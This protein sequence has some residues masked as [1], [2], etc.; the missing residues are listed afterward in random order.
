VEQFP[1]E[2]V[3]LLDEFRAYEVRRDDLMKLMNLPDWQVEALA[4][5]IWPPRGPQG[6]FDGLVP[7]VLKVRRL[8]TRLEQRV[9]LLRCVEALRLYA[10]AHDG[11]LPA[12]LADVG[13]PLPDDPVTGKPFRY[14]LDGETADV[15]GSPR[16]GQETVALF[17]VRYEVTVAR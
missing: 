1:A 16:K 15:R 7:A 3:I 10:A 14:R 17:N 9:G 4:K 5:E 8:Q 12:K 6:V 11:R 2:Q 13:V